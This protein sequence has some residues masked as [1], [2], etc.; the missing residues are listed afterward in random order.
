MSWTEQELKQV[1]GTDEL[2]VSSYAR[3]ARCARS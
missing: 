3:T 1:D 2:H